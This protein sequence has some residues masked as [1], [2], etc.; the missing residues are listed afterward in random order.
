MVFHSDGSAAS[1]VFEIR[2]QLLIVLH[3]IME[4]GISVCEN[5]IDVYNQIRQ[6]SSNRTGEIIY[7]AYIFH[8]V[9]YSSYIIN[10]FKFF[11]IIVLS[12]YKKVCYSVMYC[13]WEKPR[14]GSTVKPLI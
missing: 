10:R 8:R 13:R 2:W 14:N 9:S 1:F 7:I 11:C 4:I 6:V 3:Y 12:Y 5:E